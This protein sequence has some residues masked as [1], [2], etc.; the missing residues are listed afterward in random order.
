MQFIETELSGAWLIQPAPLHDSRGFFARTFCVREFAGRGLVTSYVQHSVSYSR[1]KGTLRGMHFQTSPHEET[2]LV[3]CHRGAI[4]DVIID[5][6]PASPTY[7]RWQA[8]RL[9]DESLRQLYVPAGFAHGFQAVCDDVEVH[10]LIS[11]FHEPAAA[12]GYRYDDP[13]FAID[14]PLPV[15]TISDRDRG[16]P[17]FAA[18]V[19]GSPG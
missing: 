2:K 9:D 16:W 14:W 4:W 12:A 10:Y 8:F 11:A 7:L 1:L 5:L 6:R 15:S 18:Q 3:S 17:A 19:A 13:A